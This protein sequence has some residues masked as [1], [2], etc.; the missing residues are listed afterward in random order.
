MDYSKLQLK[1]EKIPLDKITLDEQNAKEH[2]DWQVD[3]IV[4]SIK[5]FGNCDPIGIWGDRNLIVEG[6]GRYAALQRLGVTEADCIRLDHLDADERKAYAIAHNSTNM[7]TGFDWDKL[8]EI[9]SE[10]G[11]KFDF[12]NFGVEVD[13]LDDAA[14]AQED[15]YDLDLD[16]VPDRVKRGQVWRLGDHLLI[17]GDSTDAEIIARLFA[18]GGGVCPTRRHGSAVQR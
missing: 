14:E 2:P 17:C 9:V 18:N 11:D 5:R 6:H 7:S 16:A 10:L 13:K 8:R 12:E 4:E 15:D 1:I 3:Q